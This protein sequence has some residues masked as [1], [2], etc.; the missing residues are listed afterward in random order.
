[1]NEIQQY[2]AEEIAENCGQGQLTRSEALRRLRG[3]G[4]SAAVAIGLL[5]A[6]GS[7]DAA[8]DEPAMT[9]SSAMPSAPSAAPNS[10]ATNGVAPS[11]A[12]N[13]DTQAPSTAPVPTPASPSGM[14]GNIV[15]SAPPAAPPSDTMPPSMAPSMAPVDAVPPDQVTPPADNAGP[16]PALSGPGMGLPTEAITFNGPNGPLQA[17]FAAAANPRGAVLVI[18][19]NTGLNDHIRTVVGR[20]A[21]AGFTAIGLDLLSEEGGTASIT[22]PNDVPTQL[23]I[24]AGRTP[25]RFVTDMKAALDE[26]QRRAPNAKIGAVGFCFGGGM[27]W[28]LLASKDPRIEAAAPFYGPLPMNA[29]F[30][31]SNAAVLAFYG[32]LDMRVNATRATADGALTAAG[33]THEMVTEPGANHAFFN[34]TRPS[35]NAA[36]AADA[37]TRVLAWFSE[38]L[39]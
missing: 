23:G 15:P 8:G 37:W 30:T 32:E 36:G 21:A 33:L 26:L 3:M 31:G 25:D 11:A 22:L 28:Q 2:L 16:D 6:C 35:Y 17:A 27:I 19:E 9:T 1:M 5:S 39:S 18:H 4:L 20:F 14:E 34:D 38:N 7:D 13:T 24:I 10:A 29:D 12:P